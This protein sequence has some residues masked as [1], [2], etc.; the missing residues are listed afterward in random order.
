MQTLFDFRHE[1]AVKVL[2]FCMAALV[3]AVG[4]AFVRH[5]LIRD[6]AVQCKGDLF[7]Q[8]R[9]DGSVDLAG[10][11]VGTI[12]AFFGADMDIPD[13]WAACDGGP[14]PADSTLG[15]GRL[16]DLRGR[17]IRG[18]SGMTRTEVVSGGQDEVERTHTHLWATYDGRNWSVVMNG[19][20]AQISAWANG[21]GDDGSGQYPLD[22]HD[23]GK[24]DLHTGPG[25]DAFDNRPR[26]V[27]M[28]YII[29]VR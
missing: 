25:G 8:H 15:V 20:W 26:Y 11:P 17:F 19:E 4:V 16:P 22:P 23:R 18:S 13:G 1:P 28:R 10:V 5:V 2:A 29:R 14:V 24:M 3:L 12:V 27:E 6:Y 21:M 7:P 9:C